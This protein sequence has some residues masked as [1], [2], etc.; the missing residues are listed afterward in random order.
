MDTSDNNY[1]FKN[2]GKD[3]RYELFPEYLYNDLI[4]LESAYYNV[5]EAKSSIKFSLK[6]IDSTTINALTKKG[7]CIFMLSEKL[8]ADKLENL[9]NFRISSLEITFKGLE[10]KEYIYGQL[11]LLSTSKGK[12]IEDKK[13][14]RYYHKDFV[15]LTHARTN[16]AKLLESGKKEKTIFL[17]K[18]HNLYVGAFFSCRCRSHKK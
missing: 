6:S 2:A 8:I 11:N 7:S 14:D 13:A 5:P 3:T 12:T 10:D 1:I 18:K 15:I 16:T 9:S 17:W 4:K